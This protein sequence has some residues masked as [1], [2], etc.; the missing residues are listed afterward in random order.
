MRNVMIRDKLFLLSLFQ[1]QQPNV[2]GNASNT[3]MDTVIRVLHLI[4]NNEIELSEENFKALKN[5]KRLKS[6]LQNFDS[7]KNFLKALKLE[8]ETKRQLLKKFNSCYPY[9]LHSIFVK[10]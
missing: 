9:L 2:L 3:K 5:T 10:N 1:N 8:T 6:L 7:E 4:F